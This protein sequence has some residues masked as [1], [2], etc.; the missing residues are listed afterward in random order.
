MTRPP[1]ATPVIPSE[2]QPISPAHSK[3]ASASS[4]PF[5]R[6]PQL[7]HRHRV[8]RQPQVAR[9]GALWALPRG[10]PRAP[11]TASTFGD[12]FDS[13]FSTRRVVGATRVWRDAPD[14]NRRFRKGSSCCPLLTTLTLPVRRKQGHKTPSVTTHRTL[15]RGRNGCY[16][17]A[18]GG[19]AATTST[20]T[21]AS[22]SSWPPTGQ[23]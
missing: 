16:V 21:S 7:L 15:R 19:S 18:T 6:R 17:R 14:V 8:H 23:T 4:V 3:G 20:G 13:W 1:L 2:R 12:M 9:R 10:T 22:R 11:G 5:Q